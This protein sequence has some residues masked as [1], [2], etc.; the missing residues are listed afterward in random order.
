[1]NPVAPLLVDEE[2]ESRIKQYGEEFLKAHAAGNITAARG[3]LA[4]EIEAVNARSPAQVARMESCYFSDQGRI[5]RM[6]SQ[7]A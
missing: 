7:T 2:L 1:M 4:A 6:R 3:W 5:A